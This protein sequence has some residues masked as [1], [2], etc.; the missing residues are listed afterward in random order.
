MKDGLYH[1]EIRLPEIPAGWFLGHP[2]RLVYSR[3]AQEAFVQDRYLNSTMR[4]PLTINFTRNNVVEV[5]VLSG[6]VH[7]LVVRIP[8]SVRYDLVLAV[9]Q[10]DYSADTLRVKT[11]WLNDRTDIHSTLD[12]S[13]YIA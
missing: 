1:T 5:E 11:V 13:K 10:D 7:K 8:F 2:L 4:P 3:H 6:K 12:R 9:V